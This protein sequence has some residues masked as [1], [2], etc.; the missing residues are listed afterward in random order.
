MAH[1]HLGLMAGEDGAAGAQQLAW[2]DSLHGQA[3]QHAQARIQ[4][5]IDLLRCRR[6][7][8]HKPAH[9]QPVEQRQLE[10]HIVCQP[11]GI[12]HLH[13]SDSAS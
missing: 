10:R 5:L 12:P 2:G 7:V 13:T 1:L 4:R 11:Q 3:P 8:A 9:T 6:H